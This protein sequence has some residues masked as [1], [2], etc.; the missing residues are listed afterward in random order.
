[1][2]N[3]IKTKNGV[4]IDL[5][6]PAVIESFS[7]E[8]TSSH[9]SRGKLKV[10]SIGKTQDIRVF[11]KEFAE[12]LMKSLPG[13]P[14]VAYFD[15][16]KQ[17]FLGHNDTQYVYGYVPEDAVPE[18]IEE[19]NTTWAVV[20]VNL[21]TERDDN[22]G[23][24]A[25]QIIGKSQSLE[26][27]PDT[28]DW[29][30]V[31]INGRLEKIIFKEGSFYGLSVLGDD[32]TPAFEGA[33]FF[34]P[35]IIESL[36]SFTL[37]NGGKEMKK[38]EF[39]SLGRNDKETKLYQIIK[40]Q[41]NKKDFYIVDFTEEEVVIREYSENGPKWLI[42]NCTWIGDAEY[43]VGDFEEC[44][45]TYTRISKVNGSLADS[46]VK[47]EEETGCGTN[48]D[49]AV[50]VEESSIELPSEETE[51]TENNASAETSQD[52]GAEE[53]T[54]STVVAASEGS[55]G[56]DGSEGSDGEGQASSFIEDRD[57]NEPDES[58]DVKDDE[59]E[60]KED[61]DFRKDKEKKC[62]DIPTVA[63]SLSNEERNEL[64]ELRKEKKISLIKTFTEYLSKESI[65]KFLND[66]E[67]YDLI[68]LEA[69]LK[70]VAFEENKGRI[71]E[72]TDSHN[73]FGVLLPS[74][75]E[76]KEF[77]NELDALVAQNL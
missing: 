42:A 57:V 20:D 16:E 69:E 7:T 5:N 19:G 41:T 72:N 31:Y 4:T 70:I 33:G 53:E 35:E 32:Q 77:S 47:K 39:L 12:S 13:T 60:D 61:E 49:I 54:S 10:F 45:P 66:I 1:M 29:E 51:T 55:D 22:I 11:T 3:Y 40:E 21:F 67:K 28:V 37:E 38:N 23:E 68:T 24:V 56:S 50:Q 46:F 74:I 34:K 9:V 58:E 14:I 6:I 76:K 26:L 63:T 15:N 62:E 43:S 25:K 36:K 8:T 17:D 73:S 52:L 64:M 44:I 65:D 75:S 71:L 59:K 2:G 30:L 18:F 27:N 48:E